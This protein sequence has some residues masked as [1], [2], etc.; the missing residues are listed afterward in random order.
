MSRP[1]L[2]AID[3][4]FVIYQRPESPFRQDSHKVLKPALIST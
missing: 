1:F 3:M 2:T 4:E